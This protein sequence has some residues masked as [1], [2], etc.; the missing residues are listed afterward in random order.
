MDLVAEG[1]AGAAGSQPGVESNHEQDLPVQGQ[2]LVA[3]SQVLEPP[4]EGLEVHPPQQPGIVAD[5]RLE[6]QAHPVGLA[7]LWT[8]HCCG[9]AVTEP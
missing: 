4:T 2:D 3:L 9:A 1:V 7:C 5:A 6:G 8:D